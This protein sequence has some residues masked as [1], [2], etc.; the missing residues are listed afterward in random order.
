MNKNVIWPTEVED[1]VDSI[2]EAIED[3]VDQQETSL[4]NLKNHLCELALQKF[5][6]NDELLLTE[7]EFEEVYSLAMTQTSL[8][9][10]IAEGMIT[11]VEDSD[12]E[13]L[14]LLTDKGRQV[15]QLLP[16]IPLSSDN[17]NQVESNFS[18][19]FSLPFEQLN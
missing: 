10:L 7:N 19:I 18:D 11:F 3:V 2:I 9:K 17:E 1:Y 4:T 13:M 14:Y 16:D 15:A 8:D 5:L 6:N 12:G